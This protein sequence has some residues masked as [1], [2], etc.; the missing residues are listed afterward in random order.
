MSNLGDYAYFVLV[1]QYLQTE[2]ANFQNNVVANMMSWA[3]GIAVVLVTLWIMIQGYRI[4]TGQ[5][6]EPMMALVVN[7]ARIA[8]IVTAATSMAIFGTGLESYL[9]ANGGLASEISTL[10]AGNGSPVSAIDENM[11]ATQLTMAA[12]DVV[13]VAP[14]D[15][16]SAN[17]KA[18]DQLVATFG[19]ASPAM[20]AGAML[21]L[22]QF[23]MA[24]FVGFGPI[25]I[26]C[27]IFEQTKSMFQRW[28][29]Y[30]ISTL[31]AIALLDAVSSIVLKL[32]ENVA[33]ALWGASVING[34]M[35]N[36]VEGF[37]SQAMQQGGIG[38]LMTVLI[39]SVPPMA[40]QFFGGT[41]GNFLFQSAFGPGGARAAA[42][43]QGLPA[44][45]YGG[46]GAAPPQISGSGERQGGGGNIG[47]DPRLTGANAAAAQVGPGALPPPS[48]GTYGQAR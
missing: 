27:L 20:A 6:R 19:A 22:Y 24:I 30:G 10:V 31:F 34:L 44:G 38:L 28:L 37:D 36:Q 33:M 42:M 43:Q 18:H 15:T 4:A 5:S 1:Y 46:G 25:F 3:A 41:V 17:K 40:G 47:F 12:I 39:I 26:L 21:L 32:T 7:G 9:S 29:F 13:Q 48:A 14:G 11:A 35:G 8:M 23:A 45:A 2:I 16:E